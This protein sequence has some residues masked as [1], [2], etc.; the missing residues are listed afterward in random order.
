MHLKEVGYVGSSSM[1]QANSRPND[2]FDVF[3]YL[4]LRVYILLWTVH[5]RM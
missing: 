5:N 2:G 3:N 4:T 1:M